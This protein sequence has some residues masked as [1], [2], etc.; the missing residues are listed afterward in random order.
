MSEAEHLVEALL[1]D[2]EDPKDFIAQHFKPIDKSHL[3]VSS[4]DGGLYDTRKP[5]WHSSPPLRQNYQR[6]HP[7]INNLAEFK[8]TWRAR[9]QTNYPLAFTTD[10]GA[11][12]CEECVEKNLQRIMRS[13]RD[14]DRD[15]WRV[16]GVGQCHGSDC[17]IEDYH[18]QCA[19]CNKNLGEIA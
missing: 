19:N 8:A 18:T 15:G 6:Y 14:G 4:T 2:E 1:G 16:V 11:A 7:E 10:D 17:D 9:H 12:L 3:M 5:K 13:I